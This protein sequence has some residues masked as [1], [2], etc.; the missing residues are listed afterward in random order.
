MTI[1]SYTEEEIKKMPSQTDWNSL[2]NMSDDDI[3]YSDIPETS[4]EMFTHAIRGNIA[5][6][7]PVKVTILISP[8]LLNGFRRRTGKDWRNHLSGN[9]ETWL[10]Q[11]TT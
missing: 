4:D 3:D 2:R 1:V 5:V 10:R 11:Q 8:S 9:V 7:K 6:E